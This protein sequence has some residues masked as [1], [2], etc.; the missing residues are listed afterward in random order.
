MLRD[1]KFSSWH[2]KSMV[3]E[4]GYGSRVK[5]TLSASFCSSLKRTRCFLADPG[6]SIG[7]A[8]MSEESAG[9]D[10]SELESTPRFL[11]DK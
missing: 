7:F 5:A 3:A 6:L 2:R 4:L 8:Y 9:D 10:L 11:F 1:S